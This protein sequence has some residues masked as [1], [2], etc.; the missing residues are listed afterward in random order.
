MKKKTSIIMIAFL[1]MLLPSCSKYEKSYGYILFTDSEYFQFV[2]VKNNIFN[3]TTINSF[4]T[5]NLGE[6]FQFH[7]T[8]NMDFYHSVFYHLDTFMLQNVNVNDPKY[9]RT[10]KIVPVYI[11][12][13]KN[14]ISNRQNL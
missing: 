2:P 11:E 6:G 7:S 3:S 13:N 14:I 8:F 4:K 5:E 1:W 10:L 12:Y 9:I